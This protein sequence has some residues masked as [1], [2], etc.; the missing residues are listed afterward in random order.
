MS[1]RLRRMSRRLLKRLAFWLPKKFDRIARI[2]RDAD[3]DLLASDLFRRALAAAK[4][5]IEGGDLV[6][7]FGSAT[8]QIDMVPHERLL[9]LT[10]RPSF[11]IFHPVLTLRLLI[12]RRIVRTT[13]SSETQDQ[14]QLARLCSRLLSE[15]ELGRDLPQDVCR[16]ARRLAERC[17]WDRRS[18]RSAI[19]LEVIIPSRDGS[20][21]LQSN[22]PSRVREV[23]SM[24]IGSLLTGV[25]LFIGT[26][27]ATRLWGCR[28]LDCAV[29][30][31]LYI[32]TVLLVLG[33][34][35][36]QTTRARRAL[37]TRATCFGV[38]PI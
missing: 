34:A 32:A 18:L 17:D 31:L 14:I 38:L 25:A 2:Y 5:E 6:S 22:A 4:I 27:S 33:L 26:Y 36:L 13:Q 16:A 24:L 8:R 29:V 3:D 23:M 12:L 21:P 19:V 30:G 10:V 11:R 35:T 9:R 1:L 7:R 20:I 37:Y 28:G 15:I